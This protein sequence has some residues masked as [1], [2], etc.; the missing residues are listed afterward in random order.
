MIKIEEALQLIQQNLIKMG[1]EKIKLSEG[2][3]RVLAE[4]I[5]ARDTLP[6]FDK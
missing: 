4:D 2:L 5:Y 3:H 6:P 1:A